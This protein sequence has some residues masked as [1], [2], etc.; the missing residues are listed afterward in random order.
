MTAQIVKV[1]V[2]DEAIREQM[3]EILTIAFRRRWPESWP[4]MASARREVEQILSDG[5]ALAAQGGDGRVTGWVGG[6]PEYDGRVVELHPICVRPELQGRGIGRLLVAAFEAEA[7]ARGALTATLGSDDVDGS[8]TLSF[9]D[10]YDDLPARIAGI[11]D[12]KRHPF[13]FYEKLGYKITGVVPDAN[14]PG[15][16]DIFLSKRL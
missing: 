4:D 8:T 16:P 6:L 14:G 11:Q 9:V 13:R 2:Q 1:S 12:R 10:L 5:F 15:K 7:R 3:A